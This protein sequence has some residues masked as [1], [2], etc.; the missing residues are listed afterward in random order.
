MTNPGEGREFDLKIVF[1]I[2]N[3][4][5]GLPY[6]IILNVKFSYKNW[7]KKIKSQMINEDSACTKSTDHTNQD[8]S[9]FSVHLQFFLIKNV[10]INTEIWGK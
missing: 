7:E 1:Q 8:V 2:A 5:S 10:W 3:L 6:Y 9:L 4:N